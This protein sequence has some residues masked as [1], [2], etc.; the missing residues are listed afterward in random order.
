MIVQE[1]FFEINIGHSQLV[2]WQLLPTSTYLKTIKAATLTSTSL[3][4]GAVLMTTVGGT[5]DSEELELR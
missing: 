3:N 5:L 1:E 2:F 4:L